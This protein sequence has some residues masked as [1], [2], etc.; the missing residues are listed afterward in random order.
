MSLCSIDLTQEAA[1]CCL[2]T[3]AK[4][5]GR[6]SPGLGSQLR[7]EARRAR[8][9]PLSFASAVRARELV[10]ALRTAHDSDLLPLGTPCQL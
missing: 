10:T 2:A 5:L 1:A 3:D 4:P 7:M 6:E 8:G 9:A